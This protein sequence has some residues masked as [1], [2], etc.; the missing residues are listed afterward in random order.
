MCTCDMPTM[1]TLIFR[2]NVFIIKTNANEL[3]SSPDVLKATAVNTNA[4]SGN[5][6]NIVDN[7]GKLL[8]I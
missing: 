3:T 7:K 8:E 4:I 6:V 1:I 2:Q 5:T